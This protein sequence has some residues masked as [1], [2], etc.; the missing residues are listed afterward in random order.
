LWCGRWGPSSAEG[1]K[2]DSWSVYGQ[3][4]GWWDSGLCGSAWNQIRIKGSRELVV[5]AAQGGTPW[6]SSF[7]PAQRFRK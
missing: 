3:A 5:I 2:T 4:T 7:S 1:R 6:I